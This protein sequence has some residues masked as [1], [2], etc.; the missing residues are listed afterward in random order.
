MDLKIEGGGPLKIGGSS[1]SPDLQWATIDIFFK[2]ADNDHSYTATAEILIPKR[3]DITFAE[4]QDIARKKA[5][6]LF[7]KAADALD[8]H[9]IAELEALSDALISNLGHI[10]ELP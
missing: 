1:N 9:S 3:G 4:M 5:A 2:N 6:L 8:S 10:P 7:R